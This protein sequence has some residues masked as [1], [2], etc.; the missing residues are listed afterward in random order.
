MTTFAVSNL[1]DSGEGSLR[2]AILDA[3][4]NLGADE[5]VFDSTLAGEIITLETGEL[6]ITDDLTIDGSNGITIDG[7]QSSRI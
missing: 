4:A 3:N 1:N 5:I 7:N 6:I 2:Q